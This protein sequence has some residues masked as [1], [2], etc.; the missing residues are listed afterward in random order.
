MALG[1]TTSSLPS[2]LT[3]LNFSEDHLWEGEQTW[4]FDIELHDA[5]AQEDAILELAAIL[6]LGIIHLVGGAW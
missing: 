2:C 4:P 6:G 3:S 5:I 1:P